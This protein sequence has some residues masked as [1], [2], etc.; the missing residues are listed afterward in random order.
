MKCFFICRINIWPALQAA[1][2]SQGCPACHRAQADY[3]EMVTRLSTMWNCEN[4]QSIDFFIAD[5]RLVKG[6]IEEFLTRA[7]PNVPVLKFAFDP[8]CIKSTGWDWYP[9]QA[10]AFYKRVVASS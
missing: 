4:G 9:Q 6:V 2:Q 5:A 7:F 10:Q 1:F 3:L 8:E